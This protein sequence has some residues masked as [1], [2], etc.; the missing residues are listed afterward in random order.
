MKPAQ[1]RLGATLTAGV[2]IGIL[3][4]PSQ[5]SFTTL[6]FTGPLAA[7]VGMGF[8]MALAGAVITAVVLA[9][10]VSNPAA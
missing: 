7:C 6:L 5:A 10:A 8:R 3:T 2:T 9:L 4:I 1:P